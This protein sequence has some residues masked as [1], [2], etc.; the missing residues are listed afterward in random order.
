MKWQTHL[1]LYFGTENGLS[2]KE[3]VKKVE[4][5]GFSSALGPVDFIKVWNKEPTKEQIFDLGDKIK[6][7]LKGSGVIFNLDTHN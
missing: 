5:L 2:M 7:E 4:K 6:A 1:V 3:L